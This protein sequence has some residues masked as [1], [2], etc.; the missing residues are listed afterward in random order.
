MTTTLPCA[1]ATAE[2]RPGDASEVA[3][4]QYRAWLLNLFTELARA[5]GA[6]NAPQLG[7][8]LLLLYDGGA[9]AARMEQDRK[10]AAVAMHSA[11]AALLDAAIPARRDARRS[12][13]TAAGG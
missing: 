6:R 11:V 12:Q 7:M 9:V 4:T 3:S 1:M 10:A 5:A 13:Q 8:R 2:A